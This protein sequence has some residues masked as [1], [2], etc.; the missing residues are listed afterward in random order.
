MLRQGSAGQLA[1]S[2]TAPA[3]G[4]SDLIVARDGANQLAQ[5]NGVAAQSLRVYNTYTDGA[6]FERADMAWASN[7]LTVGSSAAGTGAARLLRLNGGGNLIDLDPAT[8]TTVYRNGT[9]GATQF[10]V[11]GS[12]LTAA[13]L[14]HTRLTPTIAQT[15]TNGYVVLD[16]NPT[17]TTVGTGTKNLIQ[18][19]IGAGANVFA[20]DRLGN[21]THTAPPYPDSSL[22]SPTTSWVTTNFATLVSP[23]FTGT[24]KSSTAIIAPNDNNTTLATTG[25]VKG[26]GYTTTAAADLAYLKLGGGTLTGPLT[27]TSATFT[28]GMTLSGAAATTVLSVPTGTVDVNG[29]LLAPTVDPSFTTRDVATTAW[30]RSLFAT[31]GQGAAV[32]HYLTPFS[33]A[34]DPLSGNLAIETVTVTP[35]DPAA[36]RIAINKT[37]ADGLL[38]YLTLF[39]PGDSLIITDE[40]VPTTFYARYDITGTVIDNGAWVQMPAVFVGSQG[41]APPSGTRVKITGYLNTATGD[42]PILGLQNGPGLT[43]YPTGTQGN[44]GIVGL[45]VDYTAVAPLAN[46]VF[47]GNP[48]SSTAIVAPND[49]NT[50]LATTAWI[51]GLGYLTATTA[52]TTYQPLD[53]TLT[54][55]AGLT[56]TAGLIEETSSDVFTKRLIGI[57]ASTS[58]PTLGDA[59]AR[60][61]AISHT[62]TIGNVTGLQTALDAKAPLASPN[63]TGVP[64]VVGP[65]PAAQTSTT[66]IATCAFVQ[67]EIAADVAGYLPLTGGTLTGALTTTGG[68]FTIDRTGKAI[69]TALNLR[70][71]AG[72]ADTVFFQT[73]AVS[74]WSL[75]KNATAESG[76]S[77][78]S[79]FQLT[80]FSDA[81]TTL[82]SVFTVA[83]ATRVMD[84]QVSPTAPTI[85]PSTTS[86]TQVAT[87]A[88]VQSVVNGASGNYLPMAGG[89]SHGRP[90]RSNARRGHRDRACRHASGQGRWPEHRRRLDLAQPWRDAHRPGHR[91]GREQRRHGDVRRQPG[92][93][94]R[95]QGPDRRR[96]HEHDRRPRRLDPQAC[97]RCDADRNGALRIRRQDDPGRGDLGHGGELHDGQLHGRAHLRR[98]DAQHDPD[99]HRQDGARQFAGADWHAYRTYPSRR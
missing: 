15:G 85:T 89:T 63:F 7:I 10:Q 79:D 82:G 73:G 13:S 27:G 69:A 83:R 35:A 33:T 46:P 56:A 70:A 19:R 30:V 48:K 31:R 52:G 6:N 28:T 74:R 75:A 97:R 80:A 71:D 60:Y 3:S 8:T 24:P 45:Q 95:H 14:L 99:R 23:T 18:G 72:F 54:A 44:Q 55:L 78:G 90:D 26:L 81:G 77:A 87:T 58:I 49:N 11:A 42:G 84:F 91:R 36:R 92:L 88:F 16:I 34:A 96:H 67:Q 38:R 53:T 51:K 59:D 43:Y 62:H 25:W 9:S 47:T 40:F 12:G 61:A 2:S 86:N 66:Q 32:Y 22:L 5:R 65:T 98:R 76:S 93:L 41:T 20:V 50:T 17:E 1:W 68:N 37:D 39:L 21:V 57:A 4:L 64:I 94:R 29:K